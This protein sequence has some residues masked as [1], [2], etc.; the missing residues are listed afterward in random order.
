[1]TNL[2]RL[3]ACLFSIVSL[4]AQSTT[5]VLEWSGTIEEIVIDEGNNHFSGANIGETFSGTISYDSISYLEFPLGP[6][7]S[8]FLLISESNSDLVIS[9]INNGGCIDSPTNNHELLTSHVLCSQVEHLNSGSSPSSSNPAPPPSPPP[10]PAANEDEQLQDEAAAHDVR[11]KEGE[12]KAPA[13][14]APAADKPP[15]EQPTDEEDAA[16]AA[17]AAAA[18]AA[19]AGRR[20]ITATHNQYYADRTKAAAESVA[21]VAKVAAPAAAP[22]AAAAEALE[23]GAS[24]WKPSAR[25]EKQNKPRGFHQVRLSQ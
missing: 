25:G 23:P 18:A 21:A 10:P 1:M 6:L 4:N 22:A 8:S 20:Q 12:L 13:P 15:A 24:G 2:L 16:A 17:P 9:I 14:P 5:V 7:Q 19:A 11:R 3:V